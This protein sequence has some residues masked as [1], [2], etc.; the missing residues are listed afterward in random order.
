MSKRAG[1]AVRRRH[2]LLQRVFGVLGATTGQPRDPVQLP[3]V[4]V[5]ELFEGGAVAGDV[6]CQ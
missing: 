3:A 5:E 1:P 2:R 4:A 6:R